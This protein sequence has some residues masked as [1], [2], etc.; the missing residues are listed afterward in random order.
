MQH[1]TMTNSLNNFRHININGIHG[2]VNINK[3]KG[4]ISALRLAQSALLKSSLL[5]SLSGGLN[6]VEFDR[7]IGI[8]VSANKMEWSEIKV[9]VI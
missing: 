8:L 7:D 1:T 4:L 2:T 6:T 5:N 9:S 3:G